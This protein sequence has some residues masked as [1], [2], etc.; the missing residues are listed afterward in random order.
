MS[1]LIVSEKPSVAAAY[2]KALGVTAKKDGYFDGNGYVITWCIGHLVGLAQPE[3]YD[4]KYAKWTVEDLPIIPQEWKYEVAADK[5]KQF[6]VVKDLMLNKDVSEVVCATDAGRE[7]ENIFR[8]VYNKA[9]CKKP[10]KRLWISS[11]EEKSIRD[12]FE[13]LKDGAEYENLY[14]AA[15]CRERA[16]WIIGM[17][18]TRLLTKLYYKKMTIGRVQTPTLEMLR[19][20]LEEISNFQKEEYYNVELF[21]EGGVGVS[22]KIKDFSDAEKIESDCAGKSAAVTS[23]KKEE[24]TVNAPKLYDLTT[25]QRE[26]NR[27]YGYTAQQ[28][29]DCV[30]ALYEKKLC[31]YPRTDSQY[32]TDDMA[33]S[34]VDILDIA[35]ENLPF[36]VG[37]SYNPANI[38]RLVN[39]KKVTDH[40]AILPTVEM[41]KTDLNSLP[42]TE[43]NILFL[44]SNKLFCA[45]GEK[46]VYETVKAELLCENHTF[47]ARGKSVT[48]EGWKETERLFKAFMKCKSDDENSENE[49]K[50][51]V[52]DGQ[53]FENCGCG[54]C[55]HWTYPPKHYTE[56]TLLSAMERAGADEVTEEVERSGLGTPAT[57]AGIIEKLIKDGY[58]NRDKKNLICT[59]SGAELVSLAPEMLKSAKFTAE[60]EDGLARMAQGKIKPND[61]MREVDELI[62]GIINE[63]K[64]NVDTSKIAQKDREV[65][66]KC[67]RCGKDV[68]DMKLAY[69][70]V[71][72]NDCNFVLWKDNKFFQYAKKTFT[73]EIAAALLKDG[74]VK[75]DGFIS[76]KTGKPYSATV[77]LDDNGQYANIKLEFDNPENGTGSTAREVIGKCPRC[78]SDVCETKLAYS[79]TNRDSCNFALWKDN[80]FFNSAKK[81]FTKEI[82]VAMLKDGKV[83]L[84]NLHSAKT[85]KPYTATVAL[86]DNGTYANFKLEFPKK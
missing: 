30:Q 38:S 65:V 63:A 64:N 50:L 24:K 57:R 76:A 74:K 72:R 16:D 14:Q 26:A 71:D 11:M 31:T 86:D 48:S 13:K 81:E 52:S 80:K 32:I 66:G 85:G 28:T 47:I 58:V 40:H 25:L 45:V 61:F 37:E 41:N 68:C 42:E 56:D 15:S 5:K 23:V 6:K 12:G 53:T 44:I 10:I 49:P 59:E 36:P 22:E 21:F 27:L 35:A 83:E 55:E 78:G 70:C 73:K 46:H 2:A 51:E 75:V 17:N 9:G 4:E 69:S 1:V 19:K 18:A 33:D 62:R 34:V 54:I 43:R 3:S 20:R 39:N 8:L 67:P 77:V 82:A 29:L 7:G 79:C 84:H 60:W